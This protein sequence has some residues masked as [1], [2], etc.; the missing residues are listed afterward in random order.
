MF[1]RHI[2]FGLAL[3]LSACS[4]QSAREPV[5]AEQQRD[6]H[7]ESGLDV[8][9]LTVLSGETVHSF[10]VE[11]ARS[12]EDQAKGLMFRTELGA[13]EG[14]IFPR[15]NPAVASFWMKN[16]PLPL[17]I[18]FVGT[19][20]KILNIAANTIPYS[21]DPV[22]AIGPTALVLEIAGGR[23]AELGIKAGDTVDWQDR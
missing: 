8:V 17:D 4:P 3:A 15:S 18:I 12:S 16:T 19:D 7:P 13:G 23:S 5:A 1:V 6:V 9:P 11:V 20:K 22:S 14:M 10:A 2:A 21:L